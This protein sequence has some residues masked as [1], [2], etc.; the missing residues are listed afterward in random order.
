LIKEWRAGLNNF[1]TILELAKQSNTRQYLGSFLET[2]ASYSA[3]GG[4]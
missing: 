2:E 4:A 3:L 1:I